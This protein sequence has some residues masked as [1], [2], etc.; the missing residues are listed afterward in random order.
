MV[1]LHFVHEDL[2]AIDYH[3]SGQLEDSLNDLQ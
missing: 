3:L 1:D 2:Q